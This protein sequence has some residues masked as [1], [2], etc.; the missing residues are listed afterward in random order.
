MRIRH[1][2]FRT[3]VNRILYPRGEPSQK[4][5]DRVAA[6]MKNDIVN[7]GDLYLKCVDKSTREMIAGARW[8]YVKPKDENAKERTWEEVDEGLIVPEPYDESE[9]ELWRNL[10]ELFNQH[11]RDLL[12][13]RP[14]YK[15]VTCV[16]LPQHQR[17]GAGAMLVQWGCEKAD[18]AGVEAY[19]EASLMGAPLYARYNFKPIKRVELNMKSFGA[20]QNEQFIVRATTFLNVQPVKN[21]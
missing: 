14:Y 16:V 21:S 19:L 2:V 5:F 3:T 10:F 4:T 8:G 20:K 17:R 1:E 15:L 9:P 12:A 6:D 11:K 13:N 18:E 7:K